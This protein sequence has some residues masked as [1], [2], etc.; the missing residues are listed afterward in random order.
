MGIL[1]DLFVVGY[2]FSPDQCDIVQ[3]VVEIGAARAGRVF[4]FWGSLGRSKG[5]TRF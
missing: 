2:C 1:V 3:M 5:S 4:R